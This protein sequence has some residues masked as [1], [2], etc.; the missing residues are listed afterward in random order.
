MVHVE[1]NRREALYQTHIHTG[2]EMV[3]TVAKM[4]KQYE[5]RHKKNLGEKARDRDEWRQIFFFLR[6]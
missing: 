4:E 2:D 5:R 6:Y 1:R 3:K